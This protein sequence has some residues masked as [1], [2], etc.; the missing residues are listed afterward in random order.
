MCAAS[1]YL[2]LSRGLNMALG[3]HARAGIV[4]DQGLPG[5]WKRGE[6]PPY[7]DRQG[8]ARR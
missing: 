1:T 2:A 6:G 7:I 5:I 3:W 8:L 4:I